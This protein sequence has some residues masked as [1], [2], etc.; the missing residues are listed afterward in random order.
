LAF[1]VDSTE[2]VSVLGLEGFESALKGMSAL[3]ERVCWKKKSLSSCIFSYSKTA[4]SESLDEQLGHTMT[5]DPEV[6]FNMVVERIGGAH[7]SNIVLG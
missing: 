1:G 6:V 2:S 4:V 3:K 7:S 5:M